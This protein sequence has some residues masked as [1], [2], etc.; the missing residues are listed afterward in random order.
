MRVVFEELLKRL[1]DME[2]DGDGPVFA[3]SA[4]VRPMAEMRVRYTPEA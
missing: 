2:Y 4:L 3:E 1:P